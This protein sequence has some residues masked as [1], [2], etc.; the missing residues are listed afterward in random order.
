MCLVQGDDVLSDTEESSDLET[1]ELINM[2]ARRNW[3]LAIQDSLQDP[4]SYVKNGQSRSRPKM[5][6]PLK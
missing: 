2:E 4:E 3:R 5:Q 1:V 6:L